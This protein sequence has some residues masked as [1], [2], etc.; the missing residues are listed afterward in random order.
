MPS[1]IRSRNFWS[2]PAAFLMSATELRSILGLF[3][4]VVSSLI[5]ERQ[6]QTEGPQNQGVKLRPSLTLTK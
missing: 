3:E 1:S 2:M 5:F 4:L 6:V